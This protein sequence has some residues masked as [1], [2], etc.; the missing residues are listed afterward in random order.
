MSGIGEAPV[1]TLVLTLGLSIGRIPVPPLARTIAVITITM[2]EREE[3]PGIF[4]LALV[5]A[6][7]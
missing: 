4:S 6:T 1:L 7:S 2:I 3:V 5:Q